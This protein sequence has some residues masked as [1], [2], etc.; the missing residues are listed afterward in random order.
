MESPTEPPATSGAK[1][2][3]ELDVRNTGETHCLI[4]QLS[5]L[6]QYDKQIFL[7]KMK[8]E[9][10]VYLASDQGYEIPEKDFTIH[11]MRHLFVRKPINLQ[12]EAPATQILAEM[13]LA[14]RNQLHD[15]EAQGDTDTQDYTRKSD[16]LKG[17]IELHGKFSGSFTN[18][19]EFT[20]DFKTMMV[21]KITESTTKDGKIIQDLEASGIEVKGLVGNDSVPVITADWTDAIPA[22]PKEQPK[23]GDKQ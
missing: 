1:E 19:V 13:I 8:F 5:T 7:R 4:C 9:Q 12:K 22:K 2:A 20:N 10:F 21:K 14:L 18:K 6:S 17:L 15:K 11:L 3:E 23:D 16:L